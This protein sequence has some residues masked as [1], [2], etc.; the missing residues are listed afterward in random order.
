MEK[1]D[2]EKY[3]RNPDM[4][5]MVMLNTLS[6]DGDMEIGDPTNPFVM[7]YEHGAVMTS[8]AVEESNANHRKM[9]PKLATKLDDIYHHMSDDELVKIFAVPDQTVQNFYINMTKLRNAGILEPNGKFKK[10][11][12]P[13]YTKITCSNVC[14]TLLNDIHIKYYPETSK[15]EVEQDLPVSSIGFE[16][17]GILDTS[18]ITDS[19]DVEWVQFTTIIKQVKI[20]T[21][22]ENIIMAEGFDNTYTIED[23]YH[24]I[25]IKHL[26]NDVWNNIS[27]TYSDMVFD[28]SVLTAHVIVVD[29][30]IRVRIPDMYIINGLLGSKVVV[31]IYTTKG[32]VEVPISKFNSSE[33]ELEI[34]PNDNDSYKAAMKEIDYKTNSSQLLEYG[35]SSMSFEDVKE[36]VIYNTQGKISIPITSK[37]LQ[38]L[39]SEKGYSLYKALDVVTDRLYVASKELDFTTAYNVPARA[40]VYMNSVR[41]VLSNLE[42]NNN[43]VVNG[44]TL[45]IKSGTL[46]KEE[47]GTVSVAT[48]Q[49]VDMIDSADNDL[50][51]S[52]MNNNNFFYTPY[53]YIV[54]KTETV[55][56]S[57]IYSIDNPIMITPRILSKNDQLKYSANILSMDVAKNEDGYSL[58]VKIVGNDDFNSLSSG[59]VF[60]Q[61]KIK[62]NDSTES[63]YLDASYDTETSMF[64][65]NIDTN[66]Y[67]DNDD[68]LNM[69][70]GTSNLSTKRI[71]LDSTL[72]FTMYI[73]DYS[74]GTINYEPTR[75]LVLD[76]MTGV[77]ALTYQN[78]RL[79]LGSKVNY[80]WNKVTTSL[81]PRTYSKYEDNVYLTYAND[82][83]NDN[84]ESGGKF[85]FIKDEEG[86][87]TDISLEILHSK[88]DYVLDENDEKIIKY[89]KGDTILDEDGLPIIDQSGG[90]V[91]FIDILM[92]ENEFKVANEVNN[93]SYLNSILSTIESW[94]SIDLSTINDKVLEKTEIQYRPV[95]KSSPVKT[96]INKTSNVMNYK[97]TP[98]I[99]LYITNEKV[100][101]S[102][103][104]ITI[105]NAIGRIIHEMI[106]SNT[107]KISDIKSKIMT[108]IQEDITAV[109]ITLDDDE[110]EIFNI[111]DNA[112]RIT[113]DKKIDFSVTNKKIVRYN[114]DLQIEKI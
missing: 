39:V 53:Q 27:I 67:I 69:T 100:Y 24:F 13:S 44:D 32:K 98:S 112:S 6:N 102:D 93:V 64:I 33:F 7:L 4:M 12:I 88:G 111:E 75:L 19:N 42:D 80:L 106:E 83:Y 18:T 74:L 3:I 51:A 43:V 40:D 54:D 65:F 70:N 91:R 87:V 97:V 46:F 25:N 11:T 79:K 96:L 30:N 90:V 58:N 61:L 82:V 47:N 59:T 113:V 28:S 22:E 1:T 62:S 2:L 5:Q 26:K 14:F 109:K 60:A 95:K 52:L 48:N 105:E 114:I 104:Y 76:D 78:V 108:N 110:V 94:L 81:L 10:V 34:G 45:I 68:G 41:M 37:E 23:Y 36:S 29:K 73:K 85:G 21:Y 35:L 38:A 9:Y 57:R 20:N 99:T 77:N 50:I 72:S 66:Y 86:S 71:P 16:N 103:D 8:A 92:L 101:S 63:I 49:E 15:V 31:E 55:V 107:V 89:A 84:T 17:L 56:Q